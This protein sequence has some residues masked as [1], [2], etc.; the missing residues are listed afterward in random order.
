MHIDYANRVESAAEAAFLEKW[1]TDR[2]VRW[3][4][5]RVSEVSRGVTDRNAY[6]K[7]SRRI[8][9]DAYRSAI[10]ACGAPA[11]FFGHHMGDVH[12]NVISN[13]MKGCALLNV[14]GIAEAS[15]VSGVKIWRPMLPHTKAD[16]YK[17][18]HTYGVPYFKDSTPEW[19]TRGR[20]RNKLMPLLGELYGEGF[21]SHLSTLSRD[22]ALCAS[23]LE[24]GFFARFRRALRASP[25]AVSFDAAPWAELPL[26]FWREALRELCE[27]YLG[28]GLVKEKAVEQLLERIRLPVGAKKQRDGWLALKKE[29][30]VLLSDGWLA[31]FRPGAFPGHHVGRNWVSTPHAPPGTLLYHPPEGEETAAYQLGAW[32]VRLSRAGGNGAT[33][34]LAPRGGG[35]SIDPSDKPNAQTHSPIAPPPSASDPPLGSIS[36]WEIL[37][38]RFEYTLPARSEY[39]VAEVIET[40]G[41]FARA[42]AHALRHVASTW[43]GML[44]AIPQVVE[45]GEPR[46][47]KLTVG[48]EF[49]SDHQT[50]S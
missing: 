46:A 21:T 10:R 22:S 25:L 42:E 36:L 41:G 26:F 48:F 31:F 14:S 16:V 33:G 20:L 40:K 28:I 4:V 17:Y 11:V 39:R 7:E 37:S 50:A 29:S 44:Q 38:G 32:R 9:F 45:G 13:V 8:R 27:Q 18:A 43:Q 15:I 5:R 49:L 24:G 47:G 23:L 3:F 2:G 19:S 12:E 6:E 1:C 35:G 34:A 30:R